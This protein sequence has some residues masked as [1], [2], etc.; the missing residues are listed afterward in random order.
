MIADQ[1]KLMS[2]TIDEYKTIG[3]TLINT[4][5]RY[6]DTEPIQNEITSIGKNS[7]LSS[8]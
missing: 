4:A 2:S 3:F 6:I 5:E 7:K 8:L 1:F